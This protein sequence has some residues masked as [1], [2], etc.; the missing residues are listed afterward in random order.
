MTGRARR[1]QRKRA[2]A[3]RLSV[4]GWERAV[5]VP[6]ERSFGAQLARATDVDWSR[7]GRL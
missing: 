2:R 5:W 4:R 6:V 7:S 3:W 1:Q